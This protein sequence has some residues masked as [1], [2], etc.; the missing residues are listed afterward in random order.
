MTEL[1]LEKLA[2]ESGLSPELVEQLKEEAWAKSENE[3]EYLIR[4][5][6]LV[7]GAVGPKGQEFDLDQE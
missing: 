6:R 2:F 4:L 7:R 1:D 3:G 5:E